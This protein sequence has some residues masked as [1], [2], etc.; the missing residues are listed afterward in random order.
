MEITTDIKP[1]YIDHFKS[2]LLQYEISNKEIRI[3]FDGGGHQDRHELM[4][5]LVKRSFN[6]FPVSRIVRFWIFTGDNRPTNT[7]NGQPL[8]SIA[9]PRTQSEYVIPD[10]HIIKWPQA[11]VADFHQYCESINL[12]SRKNPIKMSAVWRGLV[13]QNPIR[14]FIVENCLHLGET[15][16]I[17]DSTPDPN[18]SEFLQML[19]LPKWSTLVDMPG[20]G[21]SGRLKY[22]L[23][24]H[25][26]VIVFERLNW[27]AVTMC[28]EPGIHY[29]P[30]PPDMNIFKY[31]VIK[32]I[33]LNKEYINRSFETVNLIKGLTNRKYVSNMLV[34]KITSMV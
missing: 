2:Q 5:I 18:S 32:S 14:K 28:L 27:D 20:Q 8:F 22:L 33:Q 12:E 29:L 10:P 17:K 34:K 23:H 31:T 26:P 1:E 24:A 7:V 11:G 15:F 30:C 6:D 19:D 25:R 4:D 21:F 16:D 13:S 9:G 3:I